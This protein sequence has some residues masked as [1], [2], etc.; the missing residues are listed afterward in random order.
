ME[1]YR[2]SLLSSRTC[3]SKFDAKQSYRL[4]S[5]SADGK[6]VMERS[7]FESQVEAQGNTGGE[8]EG[9][10]L[11]RTGDPLLPV[12]LSNIGNTCYLN[13]LLQYL[14]TVKGVRELVNNFDKYRLEL[15]DQKIEDRKIGGNKM[16]LVRGEV[17]VAQA[18]K[19]RPVELL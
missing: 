2:V 7:L 12:G 8:Q 13:S 15:D 6:A 1:V 19:F 14:Y 11:T 3:W 18:C 4:D 10:P 9:T 5:P 16:D 17:V